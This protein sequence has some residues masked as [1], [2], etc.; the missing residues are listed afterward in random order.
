M[1]QEEIAGG[2]GAESVDLVGEH[3]LL[4]SVSTN[5]EEYTAEVEDSKEQL[6]M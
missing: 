5:T 3:R 2:G 4:I 6:F 1:K